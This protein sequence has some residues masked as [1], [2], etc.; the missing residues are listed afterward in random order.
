MGWFRRSQRLTTV[1]VRKRN[2]WTV[3]PF[4]KAHIYTQ[5]W[6]ENLRICPKCSFHDKVTFAERLELLIDEDTF[7]ELNPEITPSD[8]LG[9]ADAKGTYADK[10]E[11][12]RAKTDM[13]ESV[14]TGCGELHGIP[15]VIAIMDFRFLGGSLGGS[16]G[17]KIF[18][19][20]N[21]AL[22]KR[23]PY[24]IVSASGGARM[25]EGVV[26]L[27]QMAK[28]CAGIARLHQA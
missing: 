13:N 17:E 11:A 15:V 2:L 23:L 21:H 27:M 9:F 14:I 19:A 18:L 7:E 5:E 24:I 22:E 12:T 1:S 20:S 25:H 3:C 4:C 26:S 28:T 16:T 8:P 10:I 6:E